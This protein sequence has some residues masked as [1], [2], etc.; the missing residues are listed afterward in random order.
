MSTEST[1]P[2]PPPP[3]GENAAPQPPKLKLAKPAARVV[4]NARTGSVIFN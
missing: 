1:P 3:E 2:P 4:L